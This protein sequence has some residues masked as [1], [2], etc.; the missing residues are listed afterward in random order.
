LARTELLNLD[1][2]EAFFALGTLLDVQAAEL[3]LQSTWGVA[4][5]TVAGVFLMRA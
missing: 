3:Y 2:A 4:D 5:G 1:I